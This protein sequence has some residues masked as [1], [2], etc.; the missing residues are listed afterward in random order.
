MGRNAGREDKG[1][2]QNYYDPYGTRGEE[3]AA[4][5]SGVEGLLVSR[6]PGGSVPG[7]RRALLP[8]PLVE[9]A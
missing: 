6:G 8:A 1:R 3:P 9:V 2:Q 5:K 7:Q 4:A